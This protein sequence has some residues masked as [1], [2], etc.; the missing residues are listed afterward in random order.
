MMYARIVSK[1][2]TLLSWNVKGARVLRTSSIARAHTLTLERSLKPSKRDQELWATGAFQGKVYP[3]LPVATTWKGYA[4]YLLQ[5]RLA[6]GGLSPNDGKHHDLHAPGPRGMTV[7]TV[8]AQAFSTAELSYKMEAACGAADEPD[9]QQKPPA[10]ALL[11][12]SGSHPVR[13]LNQILPASNRWLSSSVDLLKT[14]AQMKQAGDLPPDVQ[15]WA[16]EN[17]NV[18]PVKRLVTKACCDTPL[19]WP[20]W[21]HGQILPWTSVNVHVVVEAGATTILTQPPFL[22]QAFEEWHLALDRQ[23]VLEE[24][25]LVV[26]MP[27]LSSVRNLQ[28]WLELCGVSRRPAATQLLQTFGRAQDPD[29]MCAEW[30]ISTI[31]QV[32]SLPGVAGLHVMAVTDKSRRM[33]MDL[34]RS[35][36][37]PSGQPTLP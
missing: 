28:F 37:L 20:Q 23:Q 4:S 19:E 27:I 1:T 15:L 3:D 5:Q 31:Q 10:D 34:L 36:V 2:I 16:T 22:W 30:N 35:G 25:Q 21:A 18:N 17:P 11:F 12:V 29:Q 24:C 13:Q 7:R 32:L 33:A 6:N 9:L 8:A 26:G 14:A